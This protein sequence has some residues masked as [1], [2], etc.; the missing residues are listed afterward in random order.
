MSHRTLKIPSLISLAVLLFSCNDRNNLIGE[1]KP[2]SIKFLNQLEWQ[3]PSTVD[4][5]NT[6]SLRIILIKERLNELN[7]ENSN[8]LVDSLEVAKRIDS[9]ISYY[10]QASLTL[11]SDKSF[12]MISNS[13]ILPSAIPGWHF[14]DTLMGKWTQKNDSLTLTVGDN[15]THFDF[16]YTIAQPNQNLIILKEVSYGKEMGPH[17]QITFKRK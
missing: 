16:Q 13:I 8:E 12:V 7:E 14:G 9:A 17:Q 5:T 6:D 2:V 10:Q 1:W 15:E 11:K 3:K 4:L